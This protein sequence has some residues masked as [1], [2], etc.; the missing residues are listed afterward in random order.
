MMPPRVSRNAAQLPARWRFAPLLRDR[1]ILFFDLN[2]L[3]LLLLSRVSRNAA[4]LPARWRFAPL[5]RDRLILFFDLNRLQLLLLSRVSRNAAQFPARW[6][7]APGPRERLILFFDLN[8]LQLLLP[9]CLSRT[10][11][12]VAAPRKPHPPLLNAQQGP[13]LTLASNSGKGANGG[14]L[15]GRLPFDGKMA[16]HRRAQKHYEK[17]RHHA[18]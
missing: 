14:V 18:Q 9:P 11:H 8:R 16:Y 6:R 1:L 4:Q 7:F 10:H 3:Q 2:R 5:L 17:V 12:P 15:W 13:S